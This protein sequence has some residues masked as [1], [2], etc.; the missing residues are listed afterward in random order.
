VRK[1]WPGHRL[2]ARA[3]KSRTSQF[4]LCTLS[5]RR[6]PSPFLAEWIGNRQVKSGRAKY[7]K[8]KKKKT[9]TTS[10]SA[11][12]RDHA[13]KRRAHPKSPSTAVRDVSIRGRGGGGGNRGTADPICIYLVS[14]FSR[15]F[16]FFFSSA[17]LCSSMGAAARTRVWAFIVTIHDMSVACAC[18]YE[19][20]MHVSYL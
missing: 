12:E 15:F 19:V 3:D 6:A 11:S 20:C 1:A 17:F 10:S 5:L 9:T 18:R 16:F 13:R 2:V 14:T 7:I 8:T 4:L